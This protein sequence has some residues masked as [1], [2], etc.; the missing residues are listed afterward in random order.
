VLQA[1]PITLFLV[2]YYINPTY[3]SLL[4]EEELGRTMLFYA[5]VLQILG[6]FVIKRIIDI[7]I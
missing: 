7:K 5:I 6:A 1:M 4:F 3:V 2:V